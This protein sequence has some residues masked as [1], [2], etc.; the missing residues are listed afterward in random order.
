M[1]VIDGPT[2]GPFTGFSATLLPGNRE[3]IYDVPMWKDII[4]HEE[5]I[6]QLKGYIESGKIPHALLFAGPRGLD[7]AKTAV[8]FFKALNCLASPGD[9]CQACGTCLKAERGAHPD[10]HLI[11]PGEDR[12]RILVEEIRDIIAETGLKPFEAR[13]RVIIIEPAERMNEASSNAL[14]KTLEEPP[15]GSLLILVS[16]NPSLL[17]PTLVSRCQLIRFTPMGAGA[18]AGVD[19]VLLRLTSG[20][21]GGLPAG[22]QEEALALR[23]RILDVLGGADPVGFAEKHFTD[24]EQ[25]GG[26]IT[27]FLL[28]AESILRDVLVLAHGGQGVINEEFLGMDLLKVGFHEA[29]GVAHCIRSSRRGVDGNIVQKYAVSELLMRMKAMLRGAKAPA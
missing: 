4:G 1:R 13:T 9:P 19:P 24:R 21:L 2:A 28:I 11:R 25:D 23:S 12:A 16:H 26:K 6:R 17:I 7:K 20:T 18:A 15:D 8:E 29:E 14:L 3:L 10:L 27:L 5:P 22:D